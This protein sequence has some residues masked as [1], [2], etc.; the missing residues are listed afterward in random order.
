ME[1]NDPADDCSTTFNLPRVVIY[2]VI[3][4][5]I[6]GAIMIFGD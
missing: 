5:L 2:P 4:L 3:V 1:E 6:A